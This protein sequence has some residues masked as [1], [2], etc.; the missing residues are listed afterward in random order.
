[1]NGLYQQLLQ[2]PDVCPKTTNLLF[3]IVVLEH[4]TT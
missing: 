3:S 1:M 2:N 4:V